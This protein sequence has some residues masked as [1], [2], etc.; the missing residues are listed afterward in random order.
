VYTTSFIFIPN[1]TLSH[2]LF[3]ESWIF[4]YSRT[5]AIQS[6]NATLVVPDYFFKTAV[7]IIDGHLFHGRMFQSNLP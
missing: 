4:W 3:I 6:L 1:L 2:T 5:R 7:L